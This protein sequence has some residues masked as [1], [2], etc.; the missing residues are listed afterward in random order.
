MTT[1]DIMTP[2]TAEV[3]QIETQSPDEEWQ[4]PMP[5]TDLIFDDGEPLESSRHRVIMNALIRSYRHHCAGRNNFF[6][7]GNMFVYYSTQQVKNKEFKGPDFFIV[8]DVP[9]DPARQGW[10]VWE[11]N[12]RYS[13][14]IVELLSDSTEVNDLGEKKRCTKKSLKPKIIL[15]FIPLRSTHYKDVAP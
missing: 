8:L 15:Y 6:V 14:M 13:D 3:A 5:P 2:Q 4:P 11:E 12:G 7:G 9:P 10:V 1:V